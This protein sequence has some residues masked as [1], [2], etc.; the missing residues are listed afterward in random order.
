MVSTKVVFTSA[1]SSNGVFTNLVFTN[2]VST[3]VVS[4]DVVAAITWFP[5]MCFLLKLTWFLS[6]GCLVEFTLIGLMEVLSTYKNFEYVTFF[7]N[8][9]QK[10][11]N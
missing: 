9:T 4:T 7:P 2:E 3:N 5:L 10:K 11:E 8:V 1:V 6:F